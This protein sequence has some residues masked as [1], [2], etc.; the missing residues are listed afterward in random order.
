MGLV[1][2]PTPSA[3]GLEESMLEKLVTVLLAAVLVA[4]LVW[5]LQESWSCYERGGVLV[6]GVAWFAC[7][8]TK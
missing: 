2:A 3:L 8:D 6:K 1:I 7:V 4:A 5:L